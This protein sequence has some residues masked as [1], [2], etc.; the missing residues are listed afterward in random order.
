MLHIIGVM[1][2]FKAIFQQFWNIAIVNLLMYNTGKNNYSSLSYK[3]NLNQNISGNHSCDKS[4]FN[5]K[6]FTTR[7][8]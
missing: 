2:G 3:Y 8:I 6:S 1:Y 7:N 5:S 4:G